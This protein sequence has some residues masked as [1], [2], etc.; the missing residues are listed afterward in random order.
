MYRGER[1]NSL[2]HL[3]GVV[4]AIA[5]T[6]ELLTAAS[7]RGDPWTMVAFGVFGMALVALYAASTL[8]HSLQG[9]AK[10]IWRKLD[11]AAIYLLIAG[12]FA[13]FMLVSLRSPLGWTLLAAIWILALV[14]VWHAWQRSDGRDP[15]PIPYLV[16]GWLGAIACVP[17]IDKLGVAGMGWL[18]AGGVL[19][20][21]G[22]LFYLNDRRWRHA[23]GIWHLFVLGGSASHFV[24]VLYFVN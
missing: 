20:T 7:A 23:H 1:F 9:R 24:T 5:G 6:A 13:P 14:G 22:V 8:Y 18:V 15:S 3:A 19:Y 2:T 17:L 4:L 12:T 10:D 21:A 11:H 16:M